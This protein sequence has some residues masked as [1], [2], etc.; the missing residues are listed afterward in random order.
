MERKLPPNPDVDKAG[1]YD[2][3][4]FS[5]AAI[6]DP[7]VDKK[8]T[9]GKPMLAA[10]MEKRRLKYPLIG[11]P[12]IDGYRCIIKDGVAYS[13]SLKKLPNK[14][15]QEWARKNKELLE[16]FDGEIVVGDPNHENVFKRTAE[17]RQ[18]GSRPDFTF[19]VFDLWNYRL[20]YSDRRFLLKEIFASISIH[21]CTL[22]G[23][24]VLSQWDEVEGLE[25]AMLDQ[26]YEGIILRSPHGY[27]KNGRS[28]ANEGSLVK[29]KRFTDA[30]ATITGYEPL[31]R[32]FNEP[33]ISPTGYQVRSSHKEGKQAVAMLGKV[34]CD[35]TWPDGRKCEVKIGSGF[36]EAERRKLWKVRESLPGK[37]VKF[38]YF[39][40]GSDEA[41][42]HPIF[43]G[44][45]DKWD[46]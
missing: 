36:E 30:E 28:T 8:Q 3:L 10:K 38:K 35:F 32:N 18:H 19:V 31:L 34:V 15:V 29:V 33:T 44:F 24:A 12:K 21:R 41:P 4:V 42:R 5:R 25:K 14:S 2:D 46:M 40:I 6:L 22:I 39:G 1:M 11:Q 17:V 7:F 16:G 37:V 9:F 45:R 23:E 26:G 43:L 13:R 27:Y 20:P